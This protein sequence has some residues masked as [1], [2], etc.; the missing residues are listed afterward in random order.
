LNSD[1]RVVAGD[2]VKA[3]Q[4]IGAI[5]PNNPRINGGYNP[6]L[7]FG[8]REGRVAEVG[9]VLMRML[10]DGEPHDIKIASLSED[11]ME[12]APSPAL[13]G[14]L[15][16]RMK[17]EAFSLEQREGKPCLP[18]RLLWGFSRP[19]FALVGYDLTT[20]GWRD[21]IA[22]LREHRADTQPAPY[23]LD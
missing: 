14:S 8:V 6:H 23:I 4:Q 18:A 13:A 12:L 10:V 2:I 9:A 7:H 11:Y 22:F 5:G 17:G 20:D 15:T 1:R 16:L 3:G 21:P 19:D